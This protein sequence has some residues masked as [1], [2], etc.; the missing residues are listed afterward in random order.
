MVIDGRSVGVWRFGAAGGWPLVWCHGGLSC[1][2]DAQ[3]LD[4]VARQH[5]AE[6]IAIDRPGIGR[7]D[8]WA[9]RSVSSWPKTTVEPV[10]DLLG[11]DNVAVAG[12]SGGGPYALACAAAMPDRVRAVATVGGMAP[13]LSMKQAF[14]LGMWADRVLIPAAHWTPW[15]A[16]AL[17]WS[18]RHAPDRY[19][20]RELRRIAEGDR[21]RAELEA[22]LPTLLAVHQ[23]STRR[24]V[25]GMVDEYRR[26]FGSWGFDVAQ[27]RQP[28]TVWQ[29]QHD[30]LVPLRHTR[31]LVDLL[32]AG[33]LRVI[34]STGHW[35]P[36]AVPD[37]ILEDL[38]GA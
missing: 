3:L 6:I 31:R 8:H 33:C 11:L 25:K 19:V 32:P 26:Y 23:E 20:T 16:A 13:V 38:S 12:W 30:T 1:G 9:M 2:L 4:R 15:L 5:G 22:A 28:V 24:T 17:L 14:E 34:P 21:D 27:V 29:G 7:S 36:L 18:A 35:I 37:E 10:A